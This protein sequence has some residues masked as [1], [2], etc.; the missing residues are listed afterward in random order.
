MLA[1]MTGR[2]TWPPEKK[3]NHSSPAAIPKGI[4][5]IFCSTRFFPFPSYPPIHNQI[6]CDTASAPCWMLP[7]RDIYGQLRHRRGTQ[8]APLQAR[9]SISRLKEV[10]ELTLVKSGLDKHP[11]PAPN[12]HLSLLLLLK[13]SRQ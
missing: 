4:A 13:W 8:T 1:G 11:S 10:S 9:P 2:H 3:L 12:A 5:A 6:L 7:L